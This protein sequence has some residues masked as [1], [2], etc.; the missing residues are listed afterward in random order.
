M[1]P[2]IS[3]MKSSQVSWSS[4]NSAY[5]FRRF[6][7]VG[8][9]SRYAIR[10]VASVPPFGRVSRQAGPHDRAVAPGGLHQPGVADRDPDYVLHRDGL[11]VVG[12]AVG[13]APR[14]ASGTSRPGKAA[15]V[16]RVLSSTGIT[17]RKRYQASHAHHRLVPLPSMRGPSPSPTAATSP[18]RVSTT[19]TPCGSRPSRTPSPPWPSARSRRSAS[20]APPAR[21]D[22]PL[23]A[24]LNVTTHRVAVAAGQLGRLPVTHGEVV[25][26]KR[27]HDLLIALHPTHSVSWAWWVC[28]KTS[29]PS[30]GRIHVR[31]RGVCRVF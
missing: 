18:A 5:S 16:G 30:P 19:G 24:Q 7:A 1:R 15:T 11:L 25:S 20:T 21:S 12:Q 3:T 31:Q 22:R 13:P 4:A 9:R 2:F 8:T 29:C 26:L 27:L 28:G 10:T 14:P 23:P 17:T 6:T